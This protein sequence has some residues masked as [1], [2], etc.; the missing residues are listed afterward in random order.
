MKGNTKIIVLIIVF[1]VLLLAIL[2]LRKKETSVQDEL[3][4]EMTQPLFPN[5]TADQIYRVEI[6]S[7]QNESLL[8]KKEAGSWEVSLGKDIMSELMANQGNPSAAAVDIPPQT[9][10]ANDPGP[11]GDG[12]RHFYRAQGDRIDGM[13]ETLIGLKK[14][15]IAT[16][17]PEKHSSFEV[18][19]NIIGTEVKLYDQ[20]M[21]EKA[22]LIIGKADFGAMRTYVRIPDHDEVYS[23]AGSLQLMFSPT[24][25][26]LRDTKIFDVPPESISRYVSTDND[27]GIT[28]TL[29]KLEGIWQATDQDGTVLSTV[30][31]DVDNLLSSIGSLSA[32][33]FVDQNDPSMRMGIENEEEPFFGLLT[34]HAVITFETTMGDT[35]IVNIGKKEGTTY[36]AA[37]GRDPNDIFK[38]SQTSI[39]IIRLNADSLSGAS[40]SDEVTSDTPLNTGQLEEIDPEILMELGLGDGN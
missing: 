10:P 24:L 20:N 4:G 36:Y 8:F 26:Q 25:M 32:S 16:S 6:N 34:P 37:A 40:E 35:H 11:A 5:L 18:A 33:S 12:F 7:L 27:I 13:L 23:V 30:M 22:S 9:N 38:L 2:G 1:V 19:N 14:G 15:T 39:N 3:R 17:D 28:V 29:E 31:E 21:N